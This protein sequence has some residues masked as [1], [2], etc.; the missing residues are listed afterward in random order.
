[1]GARAKVHFHAVRVDLYAQGV[2]VGEGIAR[3]RFDEHSGYIV[4][5][6]HLAEGEYLLQAAD[7]RAWAFVLQPRV[8][9][10][11]GEMSLAHGRPVARTAHASG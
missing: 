10:V 2:K 1:M 9:A 5:H 6:P 3:L 11:P 8:D 4:P 7:D